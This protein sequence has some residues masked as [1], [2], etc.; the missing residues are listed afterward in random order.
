MLST[1]VSESQLKAHKKK[2]INQQTATT[3]NDQRAGKKI[4]QKDVCL[5]RLL[6]KHQ[7]VCSVVGCCFLINFFS[8]MT[9]DKNVSFVQFNA[10]DF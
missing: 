5:I 9:S 10:E 8:K 1:E 4:P 6:I 2:L 3:A 7:S